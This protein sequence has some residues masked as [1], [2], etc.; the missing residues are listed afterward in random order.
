MKTNLILSATLVT[1]LFLC[2]CSG[3]RMIQT[4]LYFGQTIP[5]DG[6]LITPE[7]WNTFKANEISRLFKEGSSTF[8]VTGTWYDPEARKLITEPTYMVS[9]LHKRSPEFS[10]RIDSLINSYKK[11]FRQQ[12]V[13]RIDKPVNAYFK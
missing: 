12:S 5:P 2:S 11:Q 10:R 8:S 13:L 1:C 4:D 7:Q 3:S 9:H 6:T